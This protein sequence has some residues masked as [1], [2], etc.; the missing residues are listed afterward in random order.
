M[1][2]DKSE[3]ATN[4]ADSDV[5]TG[6]TGSV[7]ISHLNSTLMS[8]LNIPVKLTKPAIWGNPREATRISYV[9]G[10]NDGDRPGFDVHTGYGSGPT[11]TPTQDAVVGAV[12]APLDGLAARAE[13]VIAASDEELG[14]VD[15]TY[16]KLKPM[17]LVLGAVIAVMGVA[18][19][20]EYFIGRQQWERV[21]GDDPTVAACIALGVVI[22]IGALSWIASMTWFHRRP[23]VLR[24]HGTKLFVLAAILMVLFAAAMAY[25]F[26]GGVDAPTVGGVS[27][28][29]SASTEPATNVDDVEWIRWAIYLL[30]TAIYTWTVVIAHLWHATAEDRRR[31]EQYLPIRLAAQRAS[32]L[33]RA[34]VQNLRAATLRAIADT[35]HQG[36]D[37]ATAICTAYYAG[38]RSRLDPTLLSTWSHQSVSAPTFVEPAWL[39]RLTDAAD[40]LEQ[41]SRQ[42]THKSEIAGE[43][44]L[45]AVLPSSVDDENGRG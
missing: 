26:A 11:T 42:Q 22:M 24:E 21:L 27:G 9:L 31:V 2:N 36:V 32:V 34:G 38:V 39:R 29:T 40:R 33:D 3:A 23:G 35:W 16:P 19:L 15:P 4:V 25:S 17:W 8:A 43:F 1:H 5:T 12:Q 28:G 7:D 10:E 6:Q 13:L 37:Y 14:V 18:G 30:M 45:S 41:E 44:T 20:V